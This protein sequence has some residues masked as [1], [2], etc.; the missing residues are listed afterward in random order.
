[1]KMRPR[2]MSRLRDKYGTAAMVETLVLLFS[3]LSNISGH[4]KIL[5]NRRSEDVVQLMRTC[6]A[7]KSD[8]EKQNGNA[9]LNGVR[10]R[11]PMLA[12]PPAACPAFLPFHCQ[13]TSRTS[14]SS[15]FAFRIHG[16]FSP[17]WER[18]KADGTFLVPAWVSQVPPPKARPL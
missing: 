2:T 18:L 5:F 1:M 9:G 10:M 15:R 14:S 4:S 17:M 7:R 13:A 8:E 3:F 16:C 6:R 11:I 12:P